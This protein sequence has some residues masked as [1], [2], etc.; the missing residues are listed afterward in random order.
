MITDLLF[1]ATAYVTLFASIF[2]LT[3]FFT[4][5]RKKTIKPNHP[6]L[7]II[8]P[9]HNEEKHIEM[10]LTS[11]ENQRYPGLKILV[12]D[13]G[14]TD[15]TG[16]VVKK[17]MKKYHN[18]KYIRKQNSGK[19]SSLNCGL[20]LVGTELFGFID[21]DTFL[22]DNALL[23][24][25]GYIR[26]RTASVIATLKP[27]EPK[28]RIERLQKIEYALSSFTRK[29][30]SFVDSLYFTP[31]FAIYK[32]SVIKKLGG[33]D[34]NNITED[35]EIGLRLKNNGYRIEDSIEDSARTV[36]PNSFRALFGQRL[37][38]YRG[39]IYNSRKYSGMFFN[40][41]FGDFGIFVLPLQY[42]I[43]ALVMPFLLLSVYDAVID[44]AKG[45]IDLFVV[46]F[47]V[48]YLMSTVRMTVITPTTFFFAAVLVSFLIMM[49]L[50]SRSVVE[51]I[52]K[53][54][55][56]VYIAVY[57]FINVFLW[58]AAFAYEIARAK[59]KW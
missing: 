18:I 19:A 37:R 45:I 21:G 55:Y 22:S 17:L 33:F 9:V 59:R 11:L 40:R 44:I 32:T 56:L 47:D 10:C 57:P 13:D 16:P 29:L 39:Y 5:G 8:V 51:N 1:Y 31:G 28:T 35:L 54:D 50:S 34:E 42:L 23:N 15:R 24:M 49:R 2:W 38:W 26:G 43:L 20:K 30:L 36:V 3:T 7:S 46:N 25:T 53:M 48:A 58:V 4:A 6:P 12:V 41:R 52:G 27:Y 14:S